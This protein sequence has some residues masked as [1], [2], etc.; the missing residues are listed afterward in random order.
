MGRPVAPEIPG[1]TH[2]QVD[3]G[4]LRVHVAEAGE[5][6]PVL[7]L[8]GWPQHHYMWRRVIERLAPSYRLLA[9]DLRGFGWTDAPGSGYDGETLARDQVALLDALRL[10]R[11][12]VIGHDWGGWT[13]FLL[14]LR[15]PERIERM[16]VVNAPH[17]WPRLTPRAI[18]Q[19]PR[20]WYAAINA[21]PGIGPLVHRRPAMPR[22]ILRIG[23]PA[24]TFTA[25]EIALYAETFREPAR[26]QAMS[27]LYRY[28]H[29]VFLEALRGGF[30]SDR[31]TVPT[32]LLFGTR[33]RFISPQLVK[34][35]VGEWADALQVELVADAGHFLVD[36]QPQLV[37]DRAR[38][39]FRA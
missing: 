30:R 38:R 19:L 10:E 13:T 35:D 4:G 25:E 7:L 39:L 17:P 24:G 33:D 32:L 6:E 18:G 2:R 5:G 15:Y 27:E 8:H 36:Q 20:S 12:K 11:V 1:V 9:P 28:Y 22:T 26:A 34:G 14:G 16:V 21:T 31:L 3:A 23:A 29:R 37:S